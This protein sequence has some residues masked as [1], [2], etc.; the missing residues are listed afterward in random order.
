MTLREGTRLGAYEVLAP[1][2]SGGMGEVYRARDLRLGRDVAVKVLPEGLATDPT[3]RA[4][5]EVEAR[6]VAA[7]SHP[8]LLDIHDVGESGGISYA[9]TELLEGESLSERIKS[10]P[11]PWRKAVEFGLAAAD[12]LAA[13]H[14]RGIVHRDVKPSNIFLTSDGRVKILDFGIA[15]VSSEPVADGVTFGSTEL[16]AT[17]ALV[18]TPGFVSPEQIR[19]KPVDGRSDVFS[20]GCVL[21]EM[22]TGRRAF[23]GETAAE[24]LTA[25]LRHD[26]A[27]PADLAPGLPE[28]VRLLILRCLEKSPDRRFQTSGDLAFA[29]RVALA[30]PSREETPRPAVPPALLRTPPPAEPTR[31]ARSR[32]TLA[33]GALFAAAAGALLFVAFR[34]PRRESIESLAVLPFTNETGNPE[35]DYLSEGISDSLRNSLSTLP[36]LTVKSLP[37]GSRGAGGADPRRSGRDLAVQAVVTGRLMRHG[38]YL[39]V[40][41]DFIDVAS[42]KQIWGE[43]IVDRPNDRMTAE[44]EIA[45]KIARSLRPRLSGEEEKRVVGPPH[46]AVAWDL[47]LRG[48]YALSRRS[49]EGFEQ[50]VRFFQEARARDQNEA[51]ALMGLADTWNLLAYYGV[52]PPR[53]LFPRQREAA[54]HALRIDPSLASAHASLAD[55][56]YQYEHDWSRAETEFRRALELNPN[57]VQTL[58]WYSNF[59]SAA[60]RHPEA[61]ERIRRARELDPLNHVVAVDAALA[62]YWQG[63][64]ETARA[65][66][67]RALELDPS[68]VLGHAFLGLVN[69]RLGR[70]AEMLA[71]WRKYVDLSERHPDALAFLGFGLAKAGKRAEAETLLSELK[72]LGASQF[73]SAFPVAL[74]YLGLD[75]HRDALDALERAYEEGA[76]RLVYLNVERAFDS[77]RGDPR[78]AA[79]VRKLGI[80]SPA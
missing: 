36:W 31:V 39:V 61:L 4:R 44:S 11:I 25:T 55:L 43:R 68:Y 19:R 47:C 62:S 21:Y 33:G 54:E 9:V 66:L 79:L 64:Y 29:L 48:R 41:A 52:L 16:T 67:T 75:R 27:D 6:A 58:Q 60:G 71:E 40:Q 74:L 77:V 17:D 59:L 23:S 78:F 10:G 37:A 24:A 7:L 42:G 69:W 70:P 53:E 63:D 80:P 45:R 15:T 49:P 76:G 73:V 34:G 22:V 28:D 1:L 72:K 51:A 20:L 56:S 32:R 26:V 18:G 46:D 30:A 5:F 14:A 13:A 35:D 12:G 50:A 3:A 57:D 8:N 65:G 2:G 38:A